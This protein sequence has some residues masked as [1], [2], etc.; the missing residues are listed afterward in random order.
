MAEIMTRRGPLTKAVGQGCLIWLPGGADLLKDKRRER[1]GGRFADAAGDQA[2]R[3]G[4]QPG[5][6]G[7]RSEDLGAAGREQQDGVERAIPQSLSREDGKFGHSGHVVENLAAD[8][9]SR[10]GQQRGEAALSLGAGGMSNAPSAGTAQPRTAFAE[11]RIAV[12]IAHA[13]SRRRAPPLA[14]ASR[15]QRLKI[16]ARWRAKARTR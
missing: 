3:G 12:G 11:S 8:R 6:G 10:C 16:A 1:L 15:W 7:A 5:L 9:K 13:E 4:C 2:G 14:F